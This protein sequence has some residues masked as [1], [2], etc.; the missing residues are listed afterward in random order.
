MTPN[1]SYHQMPYGNMYM[2]PAM[3]AGVNQKPA[4]KP[5]KDG[6]TLGL[7]S[8]ILGIVSIFLFATCLNYPLMIAAVVLGIIQLVKYRQKKMAIAGIV[9]SAISLILG[10]LLLF[11]LFGDGIGEYRNKQSQDYFQPFEIDIEDCLEDDFFEI[12]F[13]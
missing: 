11:A 2:N 9:T 6:Y 1:G 8:M 13:A 10:I 5:K 7:I 3:Q 12:T 4:K